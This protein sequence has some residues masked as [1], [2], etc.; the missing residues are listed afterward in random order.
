MGVK[1]LTSYV[2]QVQRVVSDEVNLPAENA[3]GTSTDARDSSPLVIDG[4]AWIFH[5]YL[6]HFTDTIKGGDYEAFSAYLARFVQ[7]IRSVSADPIFVFDGPYLPLK[8]PTVIERQNAIAKSNSAFM[9]ST[10]RTN[11]RFQEQMGLMPPLLYDCTL[12]KLREMQVE[13]FIAQ[14]EADSVVAEMADSMGGWAVS[15]DSDFFILCARGRGCRGYV[16]LDTLEYVVKVARSQPAPEPVAQ[17][18]APEEDDGFQQVSKG[19]RKGKSQAASVQTQQPL[20]A[21]TILETPP[22]S[23][24]EATLLAVRFTSYSSAKLAANLGIPP[25]MLPLFAALVGNDYTTSVQANILGKALPNGPERVSGVAA[26]LR[27]ECQRL[28]SGSKTPNSNGSRSG[29]ATPSSRKGLG[30]IPALST[31]NGMTDSVLSTAT[32]ATATP[33]RVGM[34]ADLKVLASD[35]VREMVETVVDRILDRP[36]NT[37]LNQYIASGEKSD[38]VDS[39]INSVCTYSLLSTPQLAATGSARFFI[40]TDPILQQYQA[41]YAKGHFDKGLVEALVLRTYICK[42]FVEDPDVRSVQITHARDLRRWT[43]S[44]LFET[45]G[46]DW[47]RDTMDE[48]EPEPESESDDQSEAG[49]FKSKKI[50]WEEEG[51]PDELILVETPPSSADEASDYEA[52]EEDFDEDDLP[53]RPGSALDD[54]DDKPQGSKPPPAVLEYARKGDRLVG[55]YCQILPFDSVVELHSGELGQ[56]APAFSGEGHIASRPLD[57]RMAVYLHAHGTTEAQLEGVKKEHWPLVATLRYLIIKES[58]RLGESFRKSNFSKLELVAA[59]RATGATNVHAV[60]TTRT[61]HLMTMLQLT[62]QASYHLA[63]A[64]LLVPEVFPLPPSALV[65]GEAFHSLAL[66]PIN[67]EEIELAEE[68]KTLLGAILADGNSD[69]LSIDVEAL[70]KLKR[71]RKKA[72]KKAESKTSQQNHKQANT[73]AAARSSAFAFLDQED[74]EEDEEEEED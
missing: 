30:R 25:S 39:I 29:A 58:K 4:W 35:P 50:N 19:R 31:K 72:E 33:T 38:V 16:P 52:S 65:H 51:D 74:G 55:E 23:E 45:W 48:P 53:S 62:L 66:S 73:A 36:E 7:A 69:L 41:L 54:I 12:H 24:E 44:I 17:V 14:G 9:R 21:E 11:R 37:T 18:P 2:R 64:L 40:A 68:E 5:S 43:W 20:P 15:N 47:A 71:E 63:Q 57:I 22:K 32:S 67:V 61:I 59:L 34:A 56:A 1:G 27:E 3:K 49:F 60:P 28:L 42:Q 13:T 8:I 46:M 26:I 6:N 10:S 70:R